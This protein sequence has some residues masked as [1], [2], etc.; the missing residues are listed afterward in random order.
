MCMLHVV[1]YLIAII[2]RHTS[3]FFPGGHISGMCARFSLGMEVDEDVDD[4]DVGV[5]GG[6]LRWSKSIAERKTNGLIVAPT[7]ATYTLP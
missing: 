1:Q 6:G 4:V 7:R 2:L 3:Q 5:D